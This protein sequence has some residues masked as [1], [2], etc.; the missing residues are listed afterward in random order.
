[1]VAEQDASTTAATTMSTVADEWR[2]AAAAG[3]VRAESVAEADPDQRELLAHLLTMTAF[4]WSVLVDRRWPGTG[5]E[6]AIVIGSPG[7]FVVDGPARV[8]DLV[9][10]AVAEECVSPA[11]VTRLSVQC[12][13]PDPVWRISD[14]QLVSTLVSLPARFSDV[15]AV[16][17]RVESALAQ[18]ERIILDPAAPCKDAAADADPRPDLPAPHRSARPDADAVAKALR[19]AAERPP[20]EPWLTYLHPDQLTL[21]R[22]QFGGPARISG[23]P[24]TGKTVVALHRAAYLAAR[25]DGPILYASVVRTLPRVQA[26][27]F[28]SLATGLDGRVEFTSLSD[29]A[30]RL[31]ADRGHSVTLDEHDECWAAAW[32]RLGIGSCLELADPDPRYWK[33]EIA[34]VIKGRAVPDLESYLDLSR[35]GRRMPL[36]R[37]H[38]HAVWELYEA[39]E[40]IKKQRELVDTADLIHEA[41]AEVEREPVPYAAVIADEVQDLSVTAIRLLHALVGDAPNGLLLVGDGQQSVYPVGFPL[42]EAQIAIRGARAETLRRNYRNADEILRTAIRIAGQDPYDD[43]DGTTRHERPEIEA[44]VHGGQVV[45]VVTRSDAELDR[46]LLTIVRDLSEVRRD[47]LSGV[48]ILCARAS[49]VTRYGA[50]LARAGI[51]AHPVDEYDGRPRQA[52]NVGTVRRSK[53]LEFSVVLVPGFNQPGDEARASGQTGADRVAL[54]NRELYVA[55]T[56]ARDLLWLGEIRPPAKRR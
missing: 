7:I 25:V 20:L 36:Q 13:Q 39:Y 4:G 38:R 47:G 35:P 44:T 24:G 33:D 55:M 15:D 21:V 50:L 32:E 53:G 23:A 37:P 14:T 11:A 45:H 6:T 43:L 52:I 56:R 54:A 40:G 2:R 18:F 22:R 27:V 31:L 42:A 8:A 41:L 3:R 26:E 12:E 46:A 34:Y 48:A 19:V 49:D 29:W 10:Q 28:A 16:V 1:M 30:L 5:H 51:A 17:R 9:E